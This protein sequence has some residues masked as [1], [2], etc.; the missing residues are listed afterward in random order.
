[1]PGL[2]IGISPCFRSSGGGAD[3]VAAD[4]LWYYKFN[5]N[6]TRSY[7]TNNGG[8][9]DSVTY[10]TAPS[11]QCAVFDG[12]SFISIDDSEDFNLGASDWTIFTWVNP[13][14]ININQ[15]VFGQSTALG[16]NTSCFLSITVGNKINFYL[17]NT[18]GGYI[19]LVST[20][21]VL[22]NNWYFVSI[23]MS[24]GVVTLKLNDTQED[25]DTFASTVN[26]SLYKMS[27]GAFG[28]YRVG[29]LQGKVGMFA[30]WGRALEE[31]EETQLYNG[32]SGWKFNSNPPINSANPLQISYIDVDTI[33][34]ST[35][36]CH[37]KKLLKNENGIFSVYNKTANGS[38]TGQGWVL[39][40][41]IDNG[42]TWTD[43]HTDTAYFGPPCM[44]QD[45]S[46]NIYLINDDTIS[47]SELL[48]FSS[49][50]Y[51]SPSSFAI[52]SI[53]AGK[54]SMILD[55]D[56]DRIY[57]FK[58]NEKLKILNLSG[59]TL[60]TVTLLQDGPNA[61]CQ[62]PFFTKDA[63]GNIYFA[64]VTDD[65]L[66]PAFYRNI[67]FIVSRDL[68]VTWEKMDGTNLTLPIVADET[69]SAEMI[70]L[71]GDVLV[72]KFLSGWQYANERLHAV[73]WLDSSPNKQR[74]VR[75]N[76]T[77]GAIEKTIDL[78]FGVNGNIN[79]LDGAIIRSEVDG[80]NASPQPIYFISSIFADK[81]LAYSVSYDNG[82]NWDA[83]LENDN[84]VELRAYSVNAMTNVIDGVI[85]GQFTLVSSIST[86]Y[87]EEYSGF[88]YL[89]KL[90]V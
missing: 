39:K 9:S 44:E 25:S 74:Y 59:T 68:G 56:N 61:Y 62:Y 45:S 17:E 64:W 81:K 53:S 30:G 18:I 80:T 90:S 28:E 79:S 15:Y 11:G 82:E 10:T 72:N 65:H 54:H 3:L 40:R 60:S 2:G 20:S 13:S 31:E 86:T 78:I 75:I 8:D 7:G 55:E 49:P 89:L 29:M 32:G 26:N 24:G 23:K 22:A 6:S 76:P 58:A 21:S 67:G 47:T 16:G 19:S 38:Y 70:S 85:Y 34:Y 77:T 83:P 48:I 33:A 46:G 37:N 12:N 50:N 27:I 43:V 88:T 69:G 84:A 42:L 87:Y 63:N 4:L 5:G 35:F 14:A 71:I 36:Q 52:T 73:Y 51:G 1:M 66:G 41:S 57:Y